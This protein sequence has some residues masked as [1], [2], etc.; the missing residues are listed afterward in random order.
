MTSLVYL[1]YSSYPSL[2]RIALFLIGSRFLWNINTNIMSYIELVTLIIIISLWC[3]DLVIE[4]VSG[5]HN[6]WVKDF[7]KWGFMIF[8]FR[9]VIFFFRIFW[10]YLDTL[11]SLTNYVYDGW[12]LGVTFVDP[13]SIP[14]LN[15]LIL[16]SSGFSVT[17]FHESLLLGD[18][19]RMSILI[20]IL[21]RLRFL[22]V[23]YEEYCSIQ[24]SISDRSWSRI[25]FFRT[26]FHGFHVLCGTLFLMINWVRYVLNE[27]NCISHMSLVY[28]V[29]YWHFVDVIW[30][31]LFIIVYCMT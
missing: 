29:V 10:Y 7:M 26:G 2:L 31:I 3:G 18:C 15:T 12:F 11:Y 24:F 5:H 27:Y 25:F 21:L 17:L 4:R 13:L 30:L 6:D 16:L 20:T 28:R 19:D 14:L 9:E 22:C 8:L 23:Q 1:L